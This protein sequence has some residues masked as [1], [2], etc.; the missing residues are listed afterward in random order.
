MRT[1]NI[2]KFIEIY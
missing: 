2:L 1:I